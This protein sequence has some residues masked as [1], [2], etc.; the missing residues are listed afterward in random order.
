VELAIMRHSK[1]PRVGVAGRQ[2]LSSRDFSESTWPGLRDGVYFVSG[3]PTIDSGLA[4]W[5][6]SKS[7]YDTGIGP[8]YPVDVNARAAWKSSKPTLK[9]LA[10]HG[11]TA[12]T[13]GYALSRACSRH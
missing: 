10:A 13:D 1:F 5:A 8:L 6:A 3:Y 4:T 9:A 2:V 12:K 7:L 11:I